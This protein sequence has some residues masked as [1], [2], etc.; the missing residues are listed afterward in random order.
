MHN[1]YTRWIPLKYCILN[2]SKIRIARKKQFTEEFCTEFS[3][4]IFLYILVIHTESVKPLR[5]IIGD[6]NHAILR[7]RN[8]NYLVEFCLLLRTRIQ[9]LFMHQA[10]KSQQNMINCLY[11][12]KFWCRSS[13]LTFC[14]VCNAETHQYRSTLYYP[15]K[16]IFLGS[17]LMI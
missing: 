4:Y 6:V 9:M 7:Q 13:I 16:N 17:F 10:S 12:R 2:I 1:S 8:F 3:Q 15:N 11:E 14:R 5:G